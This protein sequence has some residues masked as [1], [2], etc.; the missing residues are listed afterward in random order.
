M[1]AVVSWQVEESKQRKRMEGWTNAL[2]SCVARR[3]QKMFTLPGSSSSPGNGESGTNN[4]TDR[5][6]GSA[7]P[8]GA[9]R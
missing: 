1:A 2:P 4:Q 7:M 9:I 3:G 8:G 6:T 5:E